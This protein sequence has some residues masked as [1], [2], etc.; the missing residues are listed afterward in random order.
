MG[1]HGPGQASL[2]RPRRHRL[3]PDR[4]P[5]ARPVRWGRR[6]ARGL[7]G[8]RV[9]PQFSHPARIARRRAARANP[10][11]REHGGGLRPQRADGPGPPGSGCA[12]R[13]PAG[14]VEP[15]P[16][17]QP[18]RRSRLRPAGDVHRRGPAPGRGDPRVDQPVPRGLGVGQPGRE[19]HQPRTSRRDAQ[20]RLLAVDGPGRPGGARTHRR[21]GDGPRAALPGGGG[22]DGRLFLSV[23]RQRHPTRDVPGRGDV[24]ALSGRGRRPGDRGLAAWERGCA[25]AR[26]A[27]GGGRGAERGVVRGEPV[28][29]LPAERARRASRRGWTSSRSCTPTR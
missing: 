4:L 20:G 21:G 7:G 18:G 6:T 8:V 19:P 2:P 1:G 16:D 13:L 17:G 12:V 9:Q 23:P 11:S 28:R 3:D 5:G 14:T 27:P 25:G 15:F 26:P 10:A 22:G 24:R 29:H